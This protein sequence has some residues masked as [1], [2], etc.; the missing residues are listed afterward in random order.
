MRRLLISFALFFPASA[1]AAPS[2]FKGLVAQFLSIINLLIPLLFGLSLVVFIW[3]IA[4]AWIIGGG[5]EEGI[6]KGKQ[7]ALAGIIGLVVMSGV[8]GIVALVKS[9]LF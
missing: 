3:G 4:N 8:W 5:D 2:D 6:R 1:Y 7:I 9:S